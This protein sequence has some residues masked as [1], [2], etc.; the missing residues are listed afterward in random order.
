MLIRPATHDDARQMAEMGAAMHAAS[1]WADLDYDA[2]KVERLV[3]DLID[4][5]QFA[6]VAEHDGHIFGLM[7]GMVLASWI[8]S[9]LVAND[10]ALY[11]AP[12]HRGGT[13]AV[14][15]VQRFVGWAL[16]R[17]AKQIRPGVSTGD[18]NGERLYERLGFERVGACFVLRAQ[19]GASAA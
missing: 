3:H 19:Q 11:V 7:I 9:D 16:E 10:F 18:A 13:A 14:R 6:V 2:D 12:E 1:S 15:L 4:A 17:G 8:G 5:R